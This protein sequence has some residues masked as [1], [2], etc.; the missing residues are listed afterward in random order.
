MTNWLKILWKDMS[1]TSK[2]IFFQKYVLPSLALFFTW[3]IVAH[4]ML[5]QLDINS[6]QKNTEEVSN[7]IIRTERGKYTHCPLFIELNNNENEFRI[8]D[9]YKDHFTTLQQK[10]LIGD[11]VTI[12]TRN[13]WQTI[14][15]WGKL[16]DIY[17]ID[18]NGET[19]FRLSTVIAEKKSQA[20]IFTIFSLILWTWYIMFRR[21]RNSE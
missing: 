13:K 2:P 12:Y 20:K 18:K 1:E 21:K 4:L 10:I 11:A 8:P 3:G 14:L 16:N 9:S 15:M 19:L 6:L 7:I 5:M 17:Q